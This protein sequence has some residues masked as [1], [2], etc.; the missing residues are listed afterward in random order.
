V[1]QPPLTG[2]I[3][4]F[5]PFLPFSAA[6]QAVIAH[7]YVLD[8][9]ERVR[10]EIKLVFSPEGQLLG[11]VYLRIRRDATICSTLAAEGY[12]KDLGAR[13]LIVAVK[14]NLEEPLVEAYLEVD[15][16]I[17]ADQDM[18]EFTVGVVQGAVTITPVGS[19]ESTAALSST[20]YLE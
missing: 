9:A 2:R 13:S 18:M 20:N 1:K 3:S 5:I 10:R 16:E 6:E 17:R 12:D 11:R 7:K 8:L 19:D 4:G 14:H 15:E